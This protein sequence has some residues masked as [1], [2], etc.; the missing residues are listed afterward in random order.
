MVDQGVV[1]L[2]IYG[3]ML[4]WAAR[5]LIRLRRMDADGLPYNLAAYRMSLAGAL[6][7]IL[8]AGMISTYITAEIT[9]WCV[10]LLAALPDPLPLPICCFTSFISC[11]TL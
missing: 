2:L 1:G 9:I 11:L 4:L 5:T 10:A 7:M 6:T 3:V 8:V